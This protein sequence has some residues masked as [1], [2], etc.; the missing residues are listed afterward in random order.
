M[1]RIIPDHWLSNVLGVPAACLKLSDEAFLSEEAAH[2]LRRSEYF[3]RG[4]IFVK[5]PTIAVDSVRA[6]EELGFRLVDTG[7]RFS[8]PMVDLPEGEA[9]HCRFATPEDMEAVM[10]VARESFVFSRF[11]LDPA[12]PNSVA[13]EIKAQWAG[14][15]FHGNRGDAMVV[16]EFKGNVV[17]FLQLVDLPQAIVI[18]LIAVAYAGRNQGLALGMINYAQKKLERRTCIQVGTQAANI[19]S[20]RLY[21][22]AGFQIEGSEYIFHH[23]GEACR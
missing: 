2:S 3:Q 12:I 13:N 11:H 5:T 8:R 18:D 22:K 14:N 19:P 1:I 9:S 17:G 21:A 10:A 20:L 6:L 23:H 15:Y 16:C 7:I 4:F